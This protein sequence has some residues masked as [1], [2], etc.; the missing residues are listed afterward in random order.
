MVGFLG[1]QSRVAAPAP[2]SLGAVRR[3]SSMR[4]GASAAAPAALSEVLAREPA[5]HPAFELL[6]V[7]MVDEYTIKCATYRHTKSGAEIISAQADDDNKV[8]LGVALFPYS[9]RN[10]K[11]R[12]PGPRQLNTPNTGLRRRLPDAGRRLDGRAAHPRALG[13]LRL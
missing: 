9:A 2:R 10:P 8:R 13:A 12:T 7:E 4:M 11:A 5:L 1:L 3:A 6:R